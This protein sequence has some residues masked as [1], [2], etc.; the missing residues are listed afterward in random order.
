MILIR[1]ALL[2]VLLLVSAASEIFAQTSAGALVGLVRDPAAAAVPGASVTVTNTQTNVTFKIATDDS[3]NYFVPSL[4]PG[5]YSV[6]CEHAGFKKLT[7]GPVTV[8]VNQ[9]V[10]VDL[11]LQVGETA[12]SVT[13]PTLIP[14]SNA[15]S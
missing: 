15:S 3:G 5:T 8:S 13:A 9:T 1:P 10:R 6:V 2:S 14:A 4:I 12:E 11:S 7:V